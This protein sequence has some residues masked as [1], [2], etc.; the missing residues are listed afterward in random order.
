MPIAALLLA[1]AAAFVHAGWNLLLS[2]AE[3]SHAAT[4]VAVLTGVVLFAPVAALSWRL[5][6]SAVPFI[7]GS[8]AT[9]VL[10][11]GLLATA[12]SVAAMS[13]VYPIARGSAPVL[14]L[15]AGVIAL[16]ARLSLPAALGVVLVGG[17]IVLVRG[18]GGAARPRDLALA[19]AVGACIAGYTL[20]DKRG[21]EHGAPISYLE[22]VFGA[23]A[24]AYALGVVSVKGVEA[25]RAAVSR[26]A[27]LAGAG[28]FA[29]YALTL[30]ALRLAPAASVAAVRESSVVIAAVALAVSGR[31]QIG[32]QR[33]AGA[34]A[35]VGGIA[36]VSL[37]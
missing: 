18:V 31:E 21:I 32:A 19:L 5:E 15:A 37:G 24:V 13:F 3:D 23:T 34:L 2:D 12:Y 33:L 26:S 27:V 29:A 16:G 17:G 10:Y 36:L 22:I 25:V 4:A 8:S 9:E 7:A 1:L 28:F 35:V 6:G 30:A 20:I 11:L 14:V